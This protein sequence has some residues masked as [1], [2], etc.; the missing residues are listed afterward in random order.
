MHVHNKLQPHVA[1]HTL[2]SQV[3]SNIKL[4]RGELQWMHVTTCLIHSKFNVPKEFERLM[5]N[6]I[7]C[8]LTLVICHFICSL[9]KKCW[10][11]QSSPPFRV[12]AL[13]MS[14][15]KHMLRVL[16]EDQ[17]NDIQDEKLQHK[18]QL[19]NCHFVLPCVTTKLQWRVCWWW[20]IT[21]HVCQNQFAS[22]CNST[23]I[24]FN[25]W[26]HFNSI[27]FQWPV[28]WHVE[29]SHRQRC[30]IE[31]VT[32]SAVTLVKH[33]T[34]GTWVT[35]DVSLQC[36]HT[37]WKFAQFAWEEEVWSGAQ[38][39]VGSVFFW[40][41]KT[42]S[43]FPWNPTLHFSTLSFHFFPSALLFF[44]SVPCNFSAH[45]NHHTFTFVADDAGVWQ[46]ALLTLICECQLFQVSCQE[47]CS[48]A[49][50]AE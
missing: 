9:F 20:K 38:P 4:W 49:L 21:I 47:M 25:H 26:I 18:C 33:C 31:E 15:L 44:L 2:R 45:A 39:Q 43:H 29:W 23:S 46:P 3:L 37:H 41:D 11:T 10:K 48:H 40:L 7:G 35:G 19:W 8:Q 5:M 34:L 42:F 28:H 17:Q 22:A 13:M 16:L 27:C 32:D 6:K 36:P 30:D 12:W 14:K 50:C 1:H 24:Q